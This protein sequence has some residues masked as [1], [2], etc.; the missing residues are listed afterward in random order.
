M[1]LCQMALTGNG[2]KKRKRYCAHQNR[3][4]NKM[5]ITQ[6]IAKAFYRKY[7]DVTPSVT[8][9]IF[10]SNCN[11]ITPSFLVTVTN[12]SY[13]YFVIKLHISLHVSNYSLT[14]ILHESNFQQLPDFLLKVILLAVFVYITVSAMREALKSSVKIYSHSSCLTPR[15]DC[16][17][18]N[19]SV[20]KLVKMLFIRSKLQ[21]CTNPSRNWEFH[22]IKENCELLVEPDDSIPFYRS[23][24]FIL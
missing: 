5:N 9:N 23:F 21:N 20:V 18:L 10:K 19:A 4:S 3:Q 12:Y 22:R 6:H 15:Q 7:S 11:S 24:E 1:K 8:L 17:Q 14:L 2:G 13:I 16:I